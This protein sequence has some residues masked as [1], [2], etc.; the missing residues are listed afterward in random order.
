MT[1][2]N[3]YFE[4]EVREGFYIP[5]MV[6]RSWATQ[7]EILESVIKICNRHDLKWFAGYGT[8]LGAVRHHGFIPWD[9]DLD[10]CML[11]DDY[12]RFVEY[13]V[14]ELPRKYAVLNIYKRNEYSNFLTRILNHDIIDTREEFMNE[15]CGFPFASGIDIF[16][17]HYLYP[18]DKKEEIR[19]QKAHKIW[20]LIE[21]NKNLGVNDGQRFI[22]EIEEISGMK[23]RLDI[24]PENAI[25]RILDAVFSEA[26]KEGATHVTLMPIWAE[27]KAQKFPIELFDNLIR[28]PFENTQ[29]LIPAA[30][31]KTLK[32][33]YG[34]WE[35]ANR[36]G[37]LHNYPFYKGQEEEMEKHYG[38]LPYK[39]YYGEDSSKESSVKLTNNTIV[40]ILDT[41]E[42]A[43]KMISL[44][45]QT[46][47]LPLTNLDKRI[48]CLPERYRRCPYMHEAVRKYAAEEPGQERIR[49]GRFRRS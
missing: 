1:F 17:L 34:N 38:R 46:K 9:D 12:D 5:G 36:K 43:C 25:Y 8:L 3:S 13:A 41:L 42:A 29:I 18:D 10:I 31:N 28:V 19:R 39:Y 47:D 40:S 27:H 7:L 45:Y 15:N 20:K 21:D 44:L 11:K 2:D 16:P 24:P 4:D 37:G 35:I 23:L 49:N 30:Y 48:S 32:L 14:R 6:K 33:I 22:R 26:P